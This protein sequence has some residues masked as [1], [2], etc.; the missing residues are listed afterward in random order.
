MIESW[1]SFVR[2]I[3]AIAGCLIALYL[4]VQ[5]TP[6]IL[7]G[8]HGARSFLA[9]DNISVDTGDNTTAM[10]LLSQDLLSANI[11][12]EL[13]SLSSDNGLDT[14]IALAYAETTRYL[15]VGGLNAND[16]RVITI[17]FNAERNEQGWRILGPWFGLIII[18]GAAGCIGFSYWQQGRGRQ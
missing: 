5:F 18:L 10:V 16:S 11:T 15:T 2:W 9:T 17:V 14:P 4:L 7:S 13:V 8:V 1:N 6:A 3:W 12:T